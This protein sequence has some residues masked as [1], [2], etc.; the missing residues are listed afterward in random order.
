MPAGHEPPTLIARRAVTRPF[1][2]LVETYG[3]GPLRGTRPTPSAA[4]AFVVMFTEDQAEENKKKKKKM[5]C[6]KIIYLRETD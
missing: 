3:P 2:P 1:R 6:L 5:Y 4:V